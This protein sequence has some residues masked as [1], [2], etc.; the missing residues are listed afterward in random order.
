MWVEEFIGLQVLGQFIGLSKISFSLDI[1][2][3]T[4]STPLPSLY[5]IQKSLKSITYFGN[6]IKHIFI[7]Q[8]L[9]NPTSKKTSLHDNNRHLEWL[10]T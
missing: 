8:N 2:Q 1:I 5:Q 7:T 3:M 6:E 9:L 4:T 10:D